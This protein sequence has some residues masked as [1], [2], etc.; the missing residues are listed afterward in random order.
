MSITEAVAQFE[1][2]E[3]DVEIALA[4]RW[5]RTLEQRALR[6]FDETAPLDD[7]D[8][9]DPRRVV[10]ARRFLVLAFKGFGKMG[11]GL[12][13]DLGLPATQPKGGRSNEARA[14]GKEDARA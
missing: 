13:N 5:R 14:K 2:N 11:R 4:E 10:E 6:I 1:R 9:I 7:F 12:F 3:R 8:T